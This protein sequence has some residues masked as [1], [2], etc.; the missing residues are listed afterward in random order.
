M[1]TNPFAPTGLSFVRNFI[2]GA[3]TYQANRATIKQ[4]YST[5]I[6]RG[7]LVKMGTSTSQGYMVLSASTDTGSYG[8]FV[9]VDP[10]YDATLQGTAHGLNGSWP[11]NANPTADVL[12][13]L[14]QDP[15]ATFAAQ[16]SGGTFAQSWIGQNINFINSSNGAPDASGRSTLALDPTTVNTTNTLP[17]RIVGVVGVTGGPQDPANTNPWLEVRLNTSLALAQTGI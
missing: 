10:Y 6:G 13:W 16:C 12:A 4:G 9:S 5:A 7:D 8:V 11:T 17:F 1:G 15:F 2:S 3:N 14:I